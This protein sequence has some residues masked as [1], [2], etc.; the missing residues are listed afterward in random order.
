[1]I[2]VKEGEGEV[3]W[4]SI[5]KSEGSGAMSSHRAKFP[6][7]CCFYHLESRLPYHLYPPESRPTNNLSS[8]QLN[9]IHLIKCS[10][11]FPLSQIYHR[12][13]TQCSI[14]FIKY[15][16]IGGHW[17]FDRNTFNSL[18]AMSGKYCVT[19]WHFLGKVLLV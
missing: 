14:L 17:I 11:N 2:N 7:R 3:T 10:L 5:S 1:M 15:I 16:T 12:A 9:R 19:A 4:S 18:I 13:K 8:N 6:G